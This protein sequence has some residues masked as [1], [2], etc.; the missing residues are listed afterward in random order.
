[1]RDALE[2]KIITIT[3]QVSTIG[4]GVVGITVN[5][6]GDEQ[7]GEAAISVIAYSIKI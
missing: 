2:K 1:L 7:S 3:I 5:V 4:T 6:T